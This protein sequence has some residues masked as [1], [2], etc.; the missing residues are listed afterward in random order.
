MDSTS[1]SAGKEPPQQ[2]DFAAPT[3]S[4]QLPHCSPDGFMTHFLSL[5]AQLTTIAP[6][7]LLSV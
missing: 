5:Q 6:S 2:L 7:A 3:I 1:P 4:H